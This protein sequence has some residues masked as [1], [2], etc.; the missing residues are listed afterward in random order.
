MFCTKDQDVSAG[1]MLVECDHSYDELLATFALDLRERIHPGLPYGFKPS[2]K[3][4][5]KNFNVTTVQ[6]KCSLNKDNSSRQ[7]ERQ[8]L[9]CLSDTVYPIIFY[10]GIVYYYSASFQLIDNLSTGN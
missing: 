9:D 7:T 4:N 1:I 10:H 6:Y 3:A 8:V 2:R 5:I